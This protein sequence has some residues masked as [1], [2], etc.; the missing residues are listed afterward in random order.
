MIKDN[1]TG[2]VTGLML[3]DGHSIA[4]NYDNKGEPNHLTFPEFSISKDASGNGW[5]N[6]QTGQHVDGPV[7]VDQ[8]TGKITVGDAQNGQEEP[9][10]IVMDDN[11]PGGYQFQHITPQEY[12]RDLIHH[13]FDVEQRQHPFAIGQVKLSMNDIKNV[14]EDP[15]QPP[16]MRLAAAAIG[17][18]YSNPNIEPPDAVTADDT[19]IIGNSSLP[20]AGQARMLLAHYP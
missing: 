9:W 1:M 5:H 6:D 17:A 2:K 19:K 18:Y 16:E 8:K 13:F 7:I 14:M 11:L 4:V 10:K 15:N 3:A 20:I 12:T